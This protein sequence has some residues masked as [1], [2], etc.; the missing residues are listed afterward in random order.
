MGKATVIPVNAPTLTD[1][2]PFYLIKEV[3]HN[4]EFLE[5]PP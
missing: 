3:H 5:K 4:P 1:N 2:R